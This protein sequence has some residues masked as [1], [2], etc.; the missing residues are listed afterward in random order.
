MNPRERYLAVFDEDARQKLDRVPTF[1]QGV[2]GGFIEKYEERMFDGFPM[3]KLTYNVGYDAAIV[4]GFDSVF[5]HIPNSVKCSGVTLKDKQGNEHKVGISGQFGKK[6]STFYHK[7][8]LF[9]QENLDE[10]WSSV[11]RIDNSKSIEAQVKEYESVSG[12]IFP[13]PAVGGI[14]D[15]VWMGMQMKYFSR[16]YRK[17]TKLYKD[18]VKYFAEIMLWNIEGLIEATGGRAGVL[19]ILDDVAFKGRP[20]ISP[21]RWE[22]DFG[23]YYEKACKMITDAGMVPQVHTDGDVTDLIP[24]F[25][26]VGFKGL[27]GWEGGADPCYIAENFPEFVV[28]G[29]ADVSEVIPFGTP[30]EIEDHV[31]MLMDALKDNRTY[32]FGPSTV[33]QK[34]DPYENVKTL[35]NCAKKYGDY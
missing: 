13:V 34:E 28:I 19:N 25:Q 22:E 14:F 12:K 26:K 5:S 7:G 27:Q 33:V 29:F 35:M 15:R 10:L 9:T 1:V 32:I 2:K 18:V 11:E 23:P 17:K 21:E 20:M 6:G 24:S 3:E 16:N 30:E 8:L 4:M 31:K